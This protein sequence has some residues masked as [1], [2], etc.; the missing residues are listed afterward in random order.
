MQLERLDLMHE[1]SLR[2]AS[3]R[4]D[5]YNLA[6]VL[7]P[8]L[9]R[10]PNPARDIMMCAVPGGPSLLETHASTAAPTS[11]PSHNP[12]PNS[13]ANNSNSNLTLGA[14]IH[15]CIERYYEVFDEMWDRSE[16]LPLPASQYQSQPVSSS[17]SSSNLASPTTQHR[18]LNQAHNDNDSDDI[19]DAMLVMPI[20]PS[21]SK[22]N[23]NDSP[24]SAWSAGTTVNG[25]STMN[26]RPGH[27][28]QGSGGLGS[29]VRSV[30]TAFGDENREGNGNSTVKKARSMVSIENGVIGGVGTVGRRGSISVGRA[31]TRK[32]SGAGV[33]ALGVT[34]VGFFT[35][36]R[37]APPVPR[38]RTGEE[39]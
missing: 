37:E 2:A 11:V 23:A 14:V 36:P 10:S 33:E 27:R 35:P 30:H 9:A 6:V 29:G 13:K 26:S 39:D 12:S 28:S 24:P 18:V 3:N 38:L 31:G 25:G 17:S 21:H 16:A 32:A 8:N 22:H 5:A 15:I 20:G 34:A 1:V 7:C 4:M 19:D